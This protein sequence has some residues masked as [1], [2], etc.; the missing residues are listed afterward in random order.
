MGR[1]RPLQGL[2][3]V[4]SLESRY[5]QFDGLNLTWEAL[6][7]LVKH[8]GPLIKKLGEYQALPWSITEYEFFERLE[9]HTN[10]G[11]EAQV[12][13][14][15]DDIAYNTHDIDDGLRAGLFSIE[16]LL[17]VKLVGPVI[18]EVLELYPRLNNL[19]SSMRVLR[20]MIDRMTQSLIEETQR[21]SQKHRP[22]T[23]RTSANMPEPVVALSEAQAA[24][25]QLKSFFDRMYR[26]YRKFDDL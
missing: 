23:A 15:S 6:E 18:K 2:R 1:I 4:T 13:A 20:R 25:Q 24:N 16:D 12:A 22:E 26:H 5:A 3:I 8:N 7:G 11:I 17:E 21:R 19:A 14:L 10:A 9:L